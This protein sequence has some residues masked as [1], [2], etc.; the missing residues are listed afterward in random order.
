MRSATSDKN[1]AR[2]DAYSP[3]RLR[4]FGHVGKLT[5]A[6]TGTLSESGGMG[7]GMGMSPNRRP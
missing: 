2:R 3:P 1:R 7:M 6:G 4:E 5:Q